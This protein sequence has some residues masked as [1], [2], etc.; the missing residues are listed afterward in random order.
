MHTIHGDGIQVFHQKPVA[1]V[2][3]VTMQDVRM[4][5]SCPAVVMETHPS[6][7]KR[8]NQRSFRVTVLKLDLNLLPKR[9]REKQSVL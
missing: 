7:V 5:E 2:K 3:R 1:E 8:L 9:E 6:A 4:S